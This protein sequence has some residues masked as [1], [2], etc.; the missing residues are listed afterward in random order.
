LIETHRTRGIRLAVHSEQVLRVAR[1]TVRRG[2]P[3]Q[4]F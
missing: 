1:L 3:L 2:S 4:K